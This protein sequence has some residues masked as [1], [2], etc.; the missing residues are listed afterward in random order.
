MPTIAGVQIPAPKSW[1]EFEEIC[2]STSKIRWESKSFTRNG[3]QGQKQDG[4]DVYGTCGKGKNIGV[5]CKN[6]IAGVDEKTVKKEIE[7]A[8]RFKPSIAELYIATTAPRDATLQKAV[9]VISKDRVVQGKFPVFVLFWDDISGDLASSQIEF[10]KHYPQFTQQ[11]SEEVKHD[12]AL[13]G[14][15]TDILRS[16]GV[17]RFLDK[18]NMAGFSFE[19]SELDPLR[20]FYYEWCVPE[21]TFLN[22]ELECL[23]E[24]LWKLADEYLEEIATETF[25]SGQEMERRSVP[26]EW[27]YERPQHFSSVVGRLHRLAG[28]IVAVHKSLYLKGRQILLKE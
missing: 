21:K 19:D 4:V 2:L 11:R 3:R 14:E 5:Q 27:E 7:K 22:V 23:R 18:T 28:E 8:E 13:F 1:D 15:L 10:L 6:T 24:M 17:I 16:N 20:K 26:E 25:T 9:R 12:K